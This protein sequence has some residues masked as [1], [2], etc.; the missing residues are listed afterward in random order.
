MLRAC[1]RLLRSGGLLAFYTIYVPNGLSEPDYKRALVSGPSA[2]STRRKDHQELLASAGF[3][4]VEETD[5]TRDFLRTSRAWYDGRGR[6][7]D[8][9]R[10]AEGSD[11]F[12]ERRQDSQQQIEAIEAG[13]LRRSLF[14]CQ[15]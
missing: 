2:V 6:F 7:A 5:L 1:R 11:A 4:R 15:S 9:L 14:I 13:L 3:S 10:A 8:Q 12:D